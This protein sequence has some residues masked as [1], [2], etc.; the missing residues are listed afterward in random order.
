MRILLTD[1]TGLLGRRWPGNWLLPA[2]RSPVSPR[3][4]WSLDPD[5]EFVG[6]SLRD[7]VL[8]QL[9]DVAD[10]VLHLAPIEPA[11]RQRRD[12][13]AGS[14]GRGGPCRCPAG[15]RVPAAGEPSLYGRPRRWWPGLG[16]E[17]RGADRAA[18]GP[19]ARLDGV[20]YRGHPGAEQ[21]PRPSRYG[22]CISTTC[23]AS[24]CSRSPSTAPA[25][26][27]CRRAGRGLSLS[28]VDACGACCC[29]RAAP[30][31]GKRLPGWV[32]LTPTLDLTTLQQRVAIR[33]RLACSRC[34]RRYRTRAGRPQVRRQGRSEPAR[35]SAVARRH[36]TC[37][38]QPLDG[39]PLR[40]AS[41][42]EQ[43]GGIRRPG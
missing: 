4:H 39:T 15:V 33:N 35:T 23:F 25:R 24:W 30:A 13:R 2:T 3:T 31:A 10:V 1:V 17:P 18:G 16:T 12:R 11:A 28:L 40:T 8:Q 38:S 21:P 7:P 37:R 26:R 43:E 41:P 29:S 9:A 19:P 27:P 36:Q 34:H 22:Y 5:V 6:A 20:P 32:Q 42:D 14:G